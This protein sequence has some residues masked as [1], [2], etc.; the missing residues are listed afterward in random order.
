MSLD[1][2]GNLVLPTIAGN[3][4]T[5]EKI[6]SETLSSSDYGRLNSLLLCKHQELLENRKVRRL[7]V[8]VAL[9]DLPDTQ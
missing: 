2:D 7:V 8:E 9:N 4:E 6:T 3:R 5:L 1:D